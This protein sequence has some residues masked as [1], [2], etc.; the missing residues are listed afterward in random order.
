M[1]K[2]VCCDIILHEAKRFMK[3]VT[4]RTLSIQ[5]PIQFLRDQSF[6]Y[7]TWNISLL[8]FLSCCPLQQNF[9]KFQGHLQILTNVIAW[10]L[11][12]K[13]VDA[14]TWI[15]EWLF[16]SLLYPTFS[17]WWDAPLIHQL[18]YYLSVES[19][20]FIMLCLVIAFYSFSFYMLASLVFFFLAITFAVTK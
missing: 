16:F 1:K 7:E 6:V 20:H 3:S 13:S 19:F 4:G 18:I 8:C 10:H 9:L 15:K 17:A 14:S 11:L 5:M 12:V 2:A